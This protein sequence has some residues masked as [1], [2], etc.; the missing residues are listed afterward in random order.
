MT[1]RNICIFRITW[2]LRGESTVIGRF[3]S[4][5]ASNADVWCLFWC[6]LN[7]V[8]NKQSNG[9]WYET[10]LCSWWRHCTANRDQ[11]NQHRDQWVDKYSHPFIF[12]MCQNEFSSWSISVVIVF[13]MSCN[14]RRVVLGK[15]EILWAQMNFRISHV[16]HGAN[17]GKWAFGTKLQRAGMTFGIRLLCLFSLYFCQIFHCMYLYEVQDIRQLYPALQSIQITF[18]YITWY[19]RPRQTKPSA[20]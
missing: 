12:N 2:P 6:L 5:R 7:K 4:Q 19:N 3:H 15:I 20:Q 1:S 14:R 13:Q 11:G 10:Q 8:L 18:V 16:T 17:P 9:L